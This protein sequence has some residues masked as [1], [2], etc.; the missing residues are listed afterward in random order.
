MVA[1]LV[2]MVADDTNA[3]RGDV[4][5]GS[6]DDDYGGDNDDDDGDSVVVAMTKV[7]EVVVMEVAV[8]WC[9]NDKSCI[10]G[11]GDDSDNGDNSAIE[12]SGGDNK[13][14]YY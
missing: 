2:V 8:V 7:I 1:M 11:S 5:G 12:G 10:G 13:K 3:G 4:D 9:D 14:Y 6:G